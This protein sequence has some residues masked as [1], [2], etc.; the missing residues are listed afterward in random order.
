LRAEESAENTNL[1]AAGEAVRRN[2]Q[3]GLAEGASRAGIVDQKIDRTEL[4]ADASE[5]RDYLVR[6]T[7]I[8]RESES[9]RS[10]TAKFVG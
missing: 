2:L 7:Y 6:L 9:F 3:E 5:S 4:L 10:C 8:R 1:P